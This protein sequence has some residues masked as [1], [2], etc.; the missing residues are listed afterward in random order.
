MEAV[1]NPGQNSKSKLLGNEIARCLKDSGEKQKDLAD[2]LGFPRSFVSEIINGVKPAPESALKKLAK[3]IEKEESKFFKLAEEDSERNKVKEAEE[4]VILLKKKFTYEAKS[5][6]M[7]FE[8]DPN[9]SNSMEEAI[10]EFNFYC[11]RFEPES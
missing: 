6:S 2:L 4:G 9:D 8:I 11:Q 1:G 10:S 7:E 5:F 3:H